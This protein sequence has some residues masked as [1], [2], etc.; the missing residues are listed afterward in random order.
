MSKKARLPLSV[1]FSHQIECFYAQR[2][3]YIIHNDII[4]Q[5]SY[6]NISH[7]DIRRWAKSER[8]PA[9][10]SNMKRKKEKK[11]TSQKTK[12]ILKFRL[13]FFFCY[14]FAK[15]M[16]PLHIQCMRTKCVCFELHLGVYQEKKNEKITQKRILAAM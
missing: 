14:A 15:I 6:R 4:G 8:V 16:K 5:N 13:L 9:K 12:N 3:A 2:Q 7:N 10:M 11:K 1:T